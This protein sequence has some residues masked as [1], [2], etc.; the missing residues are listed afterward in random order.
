MHDDVYIQVHIYIYTYIRCTMCIHRTQ[1][2][3]AVQQ[4]AE[5]PMCT[6]AACL[7][8]TCIVFYR[9]S[10]SPC[11]AV[12]ALELD[13]I[14]RYDVHSTCTGIYMY[15]VRC[16]MY[17]YDVLCTSVQGAYSYVCDV[18]CRD[19]PSYESASMY[20]VHIAI[21]YIYIYTHSI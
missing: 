9:L 16:T 3:A 20:D 4:T 18:R 1:A 19:S 14:D 13:Y 7:V 15:K 6:C 10:L 12:Q 17:S 2:E 5:R 11:G 21:I 8:C